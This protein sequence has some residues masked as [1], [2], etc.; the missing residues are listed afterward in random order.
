MPSRI[1]NRQEV[2]RLA[3]EEG[4][5][6]VDV[7]PREEY[8]YA[9]LPG[10][11][12][13]PLRRLDDKAPRLLDPDRPV[14]V[15]CCDALCDLS[16]RAAVRLEQLGF[17]YVYDYAPGKADWL[18]AG[19]PREGAAAYLVFAGD[20]ARDTVPT[21]GYG[22]PLDETLAQLR[23]AA[24]DFCVVV[25]DDQ[26][27]LGTLSARE[28]EPRAGAT[29]QDVMRQGPPTVRAGESLKPLVKRMG[30][31]ASD[32]VLV[33]D[34]EG[35]LLGALSRRDAERALERAESD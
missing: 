22:R 16:P 1:L 8:A 17:R 34:P 25:D 26:I 9:H 24:Q 18:A 32:H 2:R 19:L 28:A 31:R 21:C 15:Y 20:V 27:V 3:E 4:A 13:I 7:L 14:V 10:A 35:R 12:H 23:A 11:V 5:Q 30:K 33:T 6:L 29:V